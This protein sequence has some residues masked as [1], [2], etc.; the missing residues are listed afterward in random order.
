MAR[1]TND[2]KAFISNILGAEKAAAE[3]NLSDAGSI[4]DVRAAVRNL[5]TLENL[6]VK[7]APAETASA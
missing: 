2:D 3:S 7:L 1:L 6:I 5:D 4:N